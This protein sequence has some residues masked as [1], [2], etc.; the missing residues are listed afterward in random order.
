[1][2]GRWG[3]I[4]HTALPQS[5]DGGEGVVNDELVVHMGGCVGVHIP[6][7]PAVVLGHLIW[8]NTLHS[9]C[10]T[11]TSYLSSLLP[12]RPR[13]L[14]LLI[15]LLCIYNYSCYKLHYNHQK[16]SRVTPPVNRAIRKLATHPSGLLSSTARG[17]YGYTQSRSDVRSLVP[18]LR[19]SPH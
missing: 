19:P 9:R 8:F 4:E 13:R 5:G 18:Q 6:S 7:L 14:Q 16:M 15:P 17:G 11:L 3:M 1:M 2:S 12:Q 10:L